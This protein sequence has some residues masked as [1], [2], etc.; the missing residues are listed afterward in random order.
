M[1]EHE[2]GRLKRKDKLRGAQAR[3][4]LSDSELADVLHLT[5]TVSV[6]R[7]TNP[8][9]VDAAPSAPTLQLLHLTEQIVEALVLMRSGQADEA[10]VLLQ[11]SMTPPLKRLIR[12]RA[13]GG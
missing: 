8:E 13:P 5:T 1:T 11:R 3:L 6:R 12:D 10:R 7:F 4:K 2:C 9:R